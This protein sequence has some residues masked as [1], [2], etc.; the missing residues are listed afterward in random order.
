MRL[1]LLVIL[2][3]L[4]FVDFLFFLD[5]GDCVLFYL[6]PLRLNLCSRRLNSF[7]L[8]VIDYAAIFRVFMRDCWRATHTI[9]CEAFSV[10]LEG[11]WRWLHGDGSLLKFRWRVESSQLI[12]ERIQVL[13]RKLLS[14]V[15]VIAHL[16]VCISC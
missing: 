13:D 11:R 16:C 8:I 4:L 1:D 5:E 7:N 10:A 15:L 14:H 3:S 12:S 6:S 2:E 9:A